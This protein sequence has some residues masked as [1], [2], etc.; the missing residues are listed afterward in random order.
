MKKL[1]SVILF[2]APFTMAQAQL[3]ILSDSNMEK[4]DSIDAALYTVSYDYK[5]IQSSLAAEM[6]SFTEHMRLDIGEKTANFYSYDT[7][8]GDSIM[9][10][11]LAKGN[12]N[13]R[14]H[15][16]Q[17]AMETFTDYPSVGQ[18][19]MTDVVG[20]DMFLLQEQMPNVDWELCPDSTTTILGYQCHMAKASVLGREW[21]AWFADE[22]PMDNGPWLLRG[23]PGLILRAYT[24]DG[25]FSF[26][27]TGIEKVTRQKPILYKGA[28][29]ET[30]NRKSLA[31]AYQRYNADP[32][33]YLTGMANVK[34]TIKDENGNEMNPTKNM[35]YHLLDK[36]LEKK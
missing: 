10:A 11:E 13:S 33:G 26:D 5:F 15:T 29:C 24:A 19:S 20:M 21:S 22:L 9:A 18:Y 34:V 17:I 1:L 3:H 32:I 31:S 27:A 23:L 2:L 35:E 6:D 14:F 28:K 8:Q 25:L 7:F 12:N 36:T 30:V 16:G 4:G